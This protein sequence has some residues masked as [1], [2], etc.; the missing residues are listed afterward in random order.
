MYLLAVIV[1]LIVLATPI[2]ALVGWLQARDAHRRLGVIE[3]TLATLAQSSTPEFVAPTVAE[4]QAEPEQENTE[5]TPAPMASP[6]PSEELAPSPQVAAKKK[7]MQWEGFVESISIANILII[8][9]GIALAFFVVF[10]VKYSI[11][12]GLLGPTARIAV[13]VIF[14]FILLGLG[15][16]TRHRSFG[17]A[18]A[19]MEHDMLPPALTAA[20][21]IAL[22]ASVFAAYLLYGLL[23]S[24]VAFFLL[25]LLSA[26]AVV[27]SLVHGPLIGALGIAG[28]LLVPALIR[29]DTPSLPA[30]YG[31]LTFV[32]LGALG[33]VRL[34]RWWW[35]GWLSLTGAGA[36]IALG[37]VSGPNTPF[38][39]LVIAGFA[40]FV[41]LMYPLSMTPKAG[42]SEKATDPNDG[43]EAPAL[44]VALAASGMAAFFLLAM[45]G[46]QGPDREIL[47]MIALF[48]AGNAIIGFRWPAFYPV[49][50]I[51]AVTGIL[52]LLFW[53][54]PYVPPLEVEGE[55]GRPSFILSIPP[56]AYRFAMTCLAVALGYAAAGLLSAWRRKPQSGLWA[57]IGV[58]TSLAAIAI[59][60]W[61]ING[62]ENSIGWATI[63]IVSAV[64]Y[65]YATWS[66]HGKTNEKI[67]DAARAAFAIGVLAS[68]ALAFAMA[69]EKAWLTVALALLLP[70]MAW[71][72]TQITLP[73]L[74]RVAIIAAAIVIVRLIFNPFALD[75]AIPDVLIFNWLTYGYGI[76]ALAFYWAA[77]TY[78]Q[79][80]RDDTVILLEAGSL[81]FAVVCLTGQIRLFLHDGDLKA[82]SYLLS[83]ASLNTALWLALA[84]GLF[85][86]CTDGSSPVILYGARALLFSAL[87]HIGLIHLMALNPMVTGEAVG[88]I[89]ILNTLFLAYALPIFFLA[90]YFLPWHEARMGPVFGNGLRPA[91]AVACFVLGLIYLSF[92]VR[93]GFHGTVL[94]DGPTSDPEF[95]TYSLVWLVYGAVLITFGIWQN[96]KALRLA[97]LA[98]LLI[99]SIKIFVF[100][101]SSLDNTILRALS[102]LGLG[103]SLVP[104][105]FLYQRFVVA[106]E[107]GSSGDPPD[108][109]S[110]S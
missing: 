8:G 71:V 64:L 27:L 70:A 110:S 72:Y 60:Y 1:G 6:P 89:A 65:L 44:A 103:L 67:S 32:Q 49:H 4:P 76:P 56:D 108:P 19:I 77:R 24:T 83:E 2:L 84:Y 79:V 33:I 43:V 13:G 42:G 51:G 52:T 97:S 54:L 92:E 23:G 82:L 74:R 28:A 69:L 36:W 7:S 22:Y 85:R 87:A 90:A 48:C 30:L 109:N 81:V 95:Y 62:F 37:Q 11:E 38:E 88:N 39:L 12:Q 41:G 78:A 94:N 9:G 99:A 31:Y 101:M 53:H 104:I 59:S 86:R 45:F 102:V 20:G 91:L 16:V 47:V 15:E 10:L 34:R 17:R 21:I 3:R 18:A 75:Y 100:D 98:A 106:V 5:P 40:A 105:G 68:L 46:S 107:D 26:G 57:G 73:I 66:L 25:G 61:R 50:V 58:T 93:R 80:K 96:N 63:G 29:T 35:L 14:G 55:I